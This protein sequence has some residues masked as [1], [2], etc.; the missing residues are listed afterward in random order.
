MAK[1]WSKDWVFQETYF[2]NVHRETDKVT[3]WIR[4]NYTLANMGPNYEFSICT[5]RIFNRPETLARIFLSV[6]DANFHAMRDILTEMQQQKQQIWSGAYLITTHGR[7][8]TKLDY[9]LEILEKA[10]RLELGV[11]RITYGYG[12]YN[13]CRDWHHL[14]MH[15]EGFGDFLAAQVVADLKNTKGH[16]LQKAEDWWTF[17]APGPGSLRGLAW[18]HGRSVSE[19]SY[20][21]EIRLVAQFLNN[22]SLCMQDLQNCLCEFDKYCRVLTGSGR[23]KRKYDG[24]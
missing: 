7:K 17:S 16:P 11:K 6:K 13:T 2:C 5:A 18:F 1:P 10:Y 8:M 15:I 20:Q 22:S 23:S 21:R 12:D 3:Q 9:C 14:I 4:E 19:N 24:K